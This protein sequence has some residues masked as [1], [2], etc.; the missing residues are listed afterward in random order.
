MKTAATEVTGDIALRHWTMSQDDIN[1]HNICSY[2]FNTEC[3]LFHFLMKVYEHHWRQKITQH[4]IYRTPYIYLL[5]F[6]N[7]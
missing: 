4:V 7:I 2:I 1:R 5:V 6:L 3:I